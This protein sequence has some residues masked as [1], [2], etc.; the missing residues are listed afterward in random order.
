MTGAPPPVVQPWPLLLG[1]PVTTLHVA[2]P[3]GGVM[4]VLAQELRA[5]R[6]RVR[7]APDGS[8]TAR[9]SAHLALSLLQ[10]LE[11]VELF[12]GPV[13]T[14]RVLGEGPDGSEIEVGIRTLRADRI[15]GQVV[16]ALGRTVARLHA[17][18]VAA[19]VGPWDRWAR[20]RRFP[21]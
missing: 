4:E 17:H 2:A 9:G 12:S 15:R 16:G 1:S 21:A 3:P 10:L 8:F 18:G 6:M 20:N 14:V 11:P 5:A 13:L 7:V 19:H